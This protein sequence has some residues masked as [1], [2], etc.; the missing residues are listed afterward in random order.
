D[1]VDGLRARAGRAARGL[2]LVRADRRLRRLQAPRD[3]AQ[4]LVQ[5]AQQVHHTAEGLCDRRALAAQGVELGLERAHRLAKLADLAAELPTL[6]LPRLQRTTQAFAV[7]DQRRNRVAQ[8]VLA[9]GE[10]PGDPLRV[11]DR[12]D[13]THLAWC[14]RVLGEGLRVRARGFDGILPRDGDQLVRGA[15]RQRGAAVP[16]VDGRCAVHRFGVWCAAA[17]EDYLDLGITD[18]SI[19]EMLVDGRLGPGNDDQIPCHALSVRLVPGGR[20]SSKVRDHFPE[21][22]AEKQQMHLRNRRALLTSHFWD[23]GGLYTFAREHS[24]GNRS[25]RRARRCLP[26]QLEK[27]LVRKEVMLAPRAVS[28]RT[29][30]CGHAPVRAARAA[31]R[32]RRARDRPR[33]RAPTDPPP[34]RVAT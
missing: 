9:L 4:R 18:V 28:A 32:A 20:W 21:Q 15:G 34:A 5:L 30:R 11:V 26:A 24:S 2:P 14:L 1:L 29:T 19:A 17:V 31:P 16:A 10:P 6:L 22:R 23:L 8:L 25:A 3:V 33:R 12:L 27:I 13:L 7:L